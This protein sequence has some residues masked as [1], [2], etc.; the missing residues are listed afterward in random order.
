MER[1][2]ITANGFDWNAIFQHVVTD[3]TAVEVVQDNVPVARLEP[4]RRAVSLTALDSL[5]VTGPSLGDDVDSF[6]GDI[7]RA[8]KD[9]P[10]ESDPWAS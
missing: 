7:E 6:A 10:A 1:K 9:L 4:I 5:L 8:I 3:Q 2:E